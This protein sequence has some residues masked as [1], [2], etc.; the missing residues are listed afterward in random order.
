MDP[1]NAQKLLFFRHNRQTI[2]SDT[3][4]DVFVDMGS[5]PR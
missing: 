2:V 1:T 4:G 5:I 3:L